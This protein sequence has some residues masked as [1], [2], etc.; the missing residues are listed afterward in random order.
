MAVFA[1]PEEFAMGSPE[2]ERYR[3]RSETQHTTTDSALVCNGDKGKVTLKEFKEFLAA[4]PGVCF[5][6]IAW[7]SA[8]WTTDLLWALPGFEAAQYCSWLSKTRECAA[9]APV[10][11]H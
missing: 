7:T 8:R 2:T 6:R 11:I 4:N 10:A 5:L 1:E 3:A 9:T